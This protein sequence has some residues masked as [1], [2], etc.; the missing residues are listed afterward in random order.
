MGDEGSGGYIGKLLIKQYIRKALPEQIMKAF[1][2]DYA[3]R[4]DDILFKIYSGE[5]PS[6]YLASFAP[7]IMR[8]IDD[9]AI[10]QLVYQS[11][12]ELFDNCILKYKKARE[13]PIGFVG[14]IAYHFRDVLHK[15]AENK[16]LKVS[17]IDP[18]PSEALV[19]YHIKKEFVNA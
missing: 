1:E 12:E 17:L 14:S 11:F 19:A 15:V 3:D 18:S 10:Y 4:T 9:P 2:N 8:H 7:F 5:M 13:L 16:Q 6:R